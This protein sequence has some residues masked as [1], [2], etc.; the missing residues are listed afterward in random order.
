MLCTWK[1][2]GDHR[3]SGI[4]WLLALKSL[5][6]CWGSRHSQWAMQTK[7]KSQLDSWEGGR[8]SSWVCWECFL[9]RT[10]TWGQMRE[11]RREQVPCREWVQD[12]WAF[13]S[14]LLLPGWAHNRHMK[15]IYGKIWTTYKVMFLTMWNDQIWRVQRETGEFWTSHEWQMHSASHLIQGTSLPPGCLH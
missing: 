14:F 6:L 10:V 15:Y 13:R 5:A 8:N 3:A 7:T 4:D 11:L 9:G 12:G 2:Q 1:I